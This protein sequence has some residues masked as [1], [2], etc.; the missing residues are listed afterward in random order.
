M[1]LQATYVLANSVFQCVSVP[2]AD[3]YHLL[4]YSFNDLLLNDDQ[5]VL[6]SIRMFMDSGLVQKFKIDTKVC[7]VH[8]VCCICCMCVCVLLL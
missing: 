2:E 3:Q 8:V 1:Q 6:A 4:S 5:T 7:S